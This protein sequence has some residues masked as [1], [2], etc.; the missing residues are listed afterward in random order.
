MFRKEYFF[1]SA[2]GFLRGLKIPSL[3][4]QASATKEYFRAGF[5]CSRSSRISYALR[6]LASASKKYSRAD[7][8]CFRSSQ[9][10]YAS[11]EQASN[12]KE[13]S[14]PFAADS[15]RGLKEPSVRALTL[16]FKEYSRTDTLYSL[17]KKIF[18]SFREH[19][20]ASKKYS[21]APLL[22]PYVPLKNH[23]RGHWH[24]PLRNIPAPL[25]LIPSAAL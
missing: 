20:P 2:A 16:V 4:A 14:F 23:P 11:R 1:A 19:S 6:A 17:Y 13:Y 22:V 18:R 21:F 24:W 8:L 7:S 5:P 9:I 3:R 25:L 12:H 10:S 15:L